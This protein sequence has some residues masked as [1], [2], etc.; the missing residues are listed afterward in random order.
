MRVVMIGSNFARSWATE[1]HL[2]RDFAA[3]GHDVHKLSERVGVDVIEKEASESDLV[4]YMKAAG[5]P[6]NA[7]SMWRRLDARGVHTCS[8]HLDLYFG[9]G[10]QKE[11]K[12]D[13]F[14]RTGT[15]FTADGDPLMQ[16][17]CDSLDINHKWLPAACVS[18]EI[19]R[20]TYR[21]KW[22]Y[23][24]CFV[25]SVPYPHAEWPFRNQM[26]EHLRGRYKDQFKTWTHADQI[27]DLTSNDVYAST[28]AVVGDSVALVGHENYWS[29]RLYETVG[30]GGLLL[31]PRVPG[32]ESQLRPYEGVVYYEPRDI[33]SLIDNI[34]NVLSFN[35]ETR[36]MLTAKGMERIRQE[37][38][39]Q[40]RAQT[41]I[42]EVGL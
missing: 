36:A 3:L 27:W 11:L 35:R 9:L 2:A 6:E 8:Y 5:L 20:G 14:W 10:R 31:F 1:T 39:Y 42:R 4:V 30:R 29:N 26:I 25:G 12:V 41:I 37:H 28:H 23:P 33:D 15:V 40:H 24:L 16:A 21:D 32:V 17:Y 18:D 7:R 38:T 22:R 19:G 13:P 34:E